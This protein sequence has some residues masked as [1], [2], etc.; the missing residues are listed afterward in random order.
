MKVYLLF[1]LEWA[2]YINLPTSIWYICLSVVGS[3]FS[4]LSCEFAQLVWR[5]VY[6]L[7][8]LS[9]L[10]EWSHSSAMTWRCFS[11]NELLQFLGSTTIFLVL[12][13]SNFVT[14]YLLNASFSFLSFRYG[15]SPLPRIRIWTWSNWALRHPRK[16]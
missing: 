15:T 7:I 13:I 16:S 5:Q 9:P 10:E 3:L 14:R 12:L 1:G 6:I 11:P 4:Y 8:W 2:R